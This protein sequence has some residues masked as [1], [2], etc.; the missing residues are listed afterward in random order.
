MQP[1]QALH[2]GSVGMQCWN[3]GYQ[4]DPTHCPL[5]QEAAFPNSQGLTTHTHHEGYPGSQKR[6]TRRRFSSPGTLLR[7]IEVKGPI[8][9]QEAKAECLGPP[10]ANTLGD[11]GWA[12][13]LTRP[14]LHHSS[15][16]EVKA[17]RDP[18]NLGALIPLIH[19]Q[20]D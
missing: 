1:T 12:P 10:P 13:D 8:T 20:E 5:L 16:R 18:T 3:S 17:R 15:R 11:P 7:G 2:P 19:R 9:M 14:P 4:Q 6:A